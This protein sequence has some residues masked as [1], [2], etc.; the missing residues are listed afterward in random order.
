MEKSETKFAAVVL[1]ADRGPNDPVAREAK[2]PC[3][4]MTPIDGT[5]MVLRVLDALSASGEIGAQIL[6]GPPQAIL[7]SAP[8]LMA[9]LQSGKVEWTPHRQT[10][11]TSAY[12]AMQSVPEDRPVLVTTADHALLSVPMIDYFCTRARQSGCD[13]VAG[14]ARHEVVIQAY[15]QTRRTAT[16]LQDGAYCGCNLFAFLTPRARRAADF[17]RQVEAQRKKPLRVIR[18]MGLAAVLRYLAG[19]LSLADALERISDRLGFSAGAV[20][21]P[22]AEAAIDVD[23][24]EDLRLVE[25]ILSGQKTEDR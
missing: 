25:E 1:A 19:Q 24:P 18:V 14:V 17:W 9:R 8:A 3:K 13:V 11:S 23:S 6:C 5:P 7:D 22:F 12:H 16:R 20:T 15:P 21:M 4:S 2:T 10:P